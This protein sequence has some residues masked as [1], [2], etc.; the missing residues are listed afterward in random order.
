MLKVGAIVATPFL[1]GALFFGATGILLVDVREGGTDGTHIVIPVPLVLA[2]VALAVA[3][4][5]ARYVKCE[6]FAEYQE[7]SVRLAEELSRCPDFIIA[8]VVERDESVLVRKEGKCI[9]VDVK[10]GDE[11]VHCRVPLKSVARMLASYDGEGFST[12]S[13]IRALRSAPRGDLVHVRDGQDEV[14]ITRL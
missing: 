7:I 13:M 9:T 14:R 1:M 11:Q 12:S 5:E 10:D 8:E 2:Q 6:D 4:A 3:P